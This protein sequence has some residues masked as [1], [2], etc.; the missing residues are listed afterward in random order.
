MLESLRPFLTRI[1]NPIAEKI[2]INPNIVTL[3]SPFIALLSAIAYGEKI[4]LLGATFILLS[5]FLDVVDGAVARFHGRTSKF[6]AFLDSTIDR[7]ADGIIYIG[8]IF[9]G[10]C[11]WFIGILAIHS[12]LTI[13]YVKARAESQGVECNVGIAERAVRLIILMIGSVVGYLTAPI[14]FTYIIIFL[15]IISYITVVQRVY[16]VWRQ[17][18]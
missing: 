10:Y 13:S 9:G 14:Y 5:G 11:D 3:V 8:I 2:N 12:A 4:I 17:L 6:G 1:L 18:K 7:I 16:H 15:V